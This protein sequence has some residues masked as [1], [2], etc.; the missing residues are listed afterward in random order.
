MLQPDELPYLL[1]LQLF[2]NSSQLLST[3]DGRL[4][5]VHGRLPRRLLEEN[6]E[7][8][9]K[10]HS[11]FFI[12]DTLAMSMSNATN[13][14]KK[15]RKV[16]S[17]AS[18]LRAKGMTDENGV[19]KLDLHPEFLEF[20]EANDS[21]IHQFLQEQ[22][23]AFRPSQ[24][25]FEIRHPKSNK[26]NPIAGLMQ[27]QRN[28]FSHI[29][30]RTRNEKREARLADV[31]LEDLEQEDENLRPN[32]DDEDPKNVITLG[33]KSRL[34][35]DRALKKKMLGL[36]S[37]SEDDNNLLEEGEASDEEEISSSKKRKRQSSPDEDDDEDLDEMD[38]DEDDNDQSYSSH[39]LSSSSTHAS[40]SHTTTS[41][42]N[43]PTNSIDRI[44]SKS[45]VP[46]AKKAKHGAQKK[47]AAGG[48]DASWR[49]EKFFMS[50]ISSTTATDIGLAIKEAPKTIEDMVLDLNPDDDRSIFRKKSLMTWDKRKKKFVATQ[51]TENGKKELRVRNESGQL[52]IVGAKNRGKLYRQWSEKTHKSIPSLGEIEDE[53]PTASSGKKK[54][55]ANND[56]DGPNAPAPVGYGPGGA[57]HEGPMLTP[58]RY[59]YTSGSHGSSKPDGVKSA[60]EIQSNLKGRHGGKREVKSELKSRDE[61]KKNKTEEAKKQYLQS[62]NK[63]PGGGRSGG[64][65]GGGGGGKRRYSRS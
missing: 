22:L 55:R 30:T 46:K 34:E 44:L 2:L 19:M 6:V 16:P 27:L 14:Y 32:G 53:N 63:R 31:E 28:K 12:L 18:V 59:R 29:I 49:D 21:A 60:R 62:K 57:S 7:E 37:D 26:E 11:R 13:L 23:R 54:R 39:R 52:I 61:L 36:D 50:G 33:S 58:A 5:C 20:E 4:N 42:S 25:I 35:I 41:S 17:R 45:V 9:T 1:D 65:G 24:N 8:V 3:L 56:E 38:V 51:D 43:A 15:T 48:A 40:S 64:G 10:L 47:K